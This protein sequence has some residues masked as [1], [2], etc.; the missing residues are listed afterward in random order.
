MFYGFGSVNNFTENVTS[1]RYLRFSRREVYATISFELLLLILL[2]PHCCIVW[3]INCS[4]F[5]IYT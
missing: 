1:E 3:E 5:S 2:R 4:L